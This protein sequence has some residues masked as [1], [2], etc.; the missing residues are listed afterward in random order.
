MMKYAFLAGVM[1]IS[2]P[3][4]AQSTTTSDPVATT[5]QSSATPTG[6]DPQNVP[7]QPSPAPQTTAPS[8]PA[9]AE[10]QATGDQIATVVNQEFPIYDKDGDGAL[11]KAE[12]SGWMLALKSASD[13]STKAEDPKTKTWMTQAFAQADSDKSQSVTKAELTAFLAQATKAS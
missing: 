3:A 9:A 6:T 2:L 4:F 8:D 11:N 10:P 5:S 1:M 13:P 7:A 12:F